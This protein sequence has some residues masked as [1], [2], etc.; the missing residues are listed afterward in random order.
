M[1]KQRKLKKWVISTLAGINFL[2]LIV[3]GSDSKDLSVFIIVHIIAVAV[4]ILSG[5][6]LLKNDRD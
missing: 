6:I 5:Y 3:M 1:I 4:F 2:S